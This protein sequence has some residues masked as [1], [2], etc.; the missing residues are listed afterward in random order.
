[1]LAGIGLRLRILSVF[2]LGVAYF[3]FD[4]IEGALIEV[5]FD[6]LVSLALAAY[7]VF[8]LVWRGSTSGLRPK[9]FAIAGLYVL[10]FILDTFVFVSGS[11]LDEV[12]SF[13]VTF[14]I[15]PFLLFPKLRFWR[16]G[17]SA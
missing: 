17:Q 13:L 2:L 9:G 15:V 4:I 7:A 10:L 5:R 3:L 1:M 6:E 16:K 11:S 14:V 12:C 8:A